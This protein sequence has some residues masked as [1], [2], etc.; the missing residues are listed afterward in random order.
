MKNK[1]IQWLLTAILATSGSLLMAQPV[2]LNPLATS[3]DI[4]V[5][6]PPTTNNTGNDI[7][8]VPFAPPSNLVNVMV[9]ENGPNVFLTHQNVGNNSPGTVITLGTM[10]P[11]GTIFFDPDVV[12]VVSGG[13]G[14]GALK[15]WIIVVYIADTPGPSAPTIFA[16]MYNW[17]GTTFSLVGGPYDLSNS[18]GVLPCNSPNIDA[19]YLGNYA[20]VWE[21]DNEIFMAS[22][23]AF[24]TFPNQ[25]SHFIN[26]S[27]SCSLSGNERSPDVCIIPDGG[28]NSLI[29]VTFTNTANDILYLERIFTNQI[30]G[31]PGTYP[32]PPSNCAS[33]MFY[34]QSFVSLGTIHDPR[35]ACPPSTSGTRNILDMTIAFQFIYSTSPFNSH[36]VT[37]TH[38]LINYPPAGSIVYNRLDVAGSSFPAYGPNYTNQKPAI[39]YKQVIDEFVV[40]WELQDLSTGANNAY[41]PVNN[42]FNLVA[43]KCTD[44]NIPVNVDMSSVNNVTTSSNQARSVS[45][46]KGDIPPMQYGFVKDN[47]VI[48]YN[49]V[50][51]GSN[52]KKENPGKIWFID[53]S[54]STTDVPDFTTNSEIKMYPN[55]VAFNGGDIHLDLNNTTVSEISI[56]TIDGK[57][58][59]HLDI[60]NQ[61]TVTIPNQFPKG[62]YFVVIKS[63]NTQETKKLMIQ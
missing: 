28:T 4:Y 53:Y 5:S 61:S 6:G 31:L 3:E 48:R 26:H 37:A 14:I 10:L 33:P 39:A 35:I 60:E 21:E 11:P 43:V 41:S 38:N 18:G 44:A 45:I 2:I 32:F 58:V 36:L 17:G 12:S 25:P 57:Q 42:N 40:A 19:D 54:H 13:T 15:E 7:C 47:N 1:P 56:M 51:S 34:A 62:A 23:N 50:F 27:I 16:E 20:I 46:S 55:P 59:Y 22:E 24:G 30:P 63:D 9:Y 49:S 29:N 52:L 8:H